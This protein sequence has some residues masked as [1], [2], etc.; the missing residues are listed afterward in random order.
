V[1]SARDWTGHVERCTSKPIK[2]LGRNQRDNEEDQA[3]YD[4]GNDGQEAEE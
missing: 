2:G 4:P 1:K 3:D